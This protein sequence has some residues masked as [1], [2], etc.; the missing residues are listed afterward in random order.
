MCTIITW[1]ELSWQELSWQPLPCFLA[2][3][4]LGEWP[5]GSCTG[6]KWVHENRRLH[7][8]HVTPSATHHGN[9]NPTSCLLFDKKKRKQFI[10]F[11]LG[12]E[13]TPSPATTYSD[14][15]E[16]RISKHE[17]LTSRPPLR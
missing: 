14:T 12:I 10:D 16:K 6:G 15:K 7:R 3:S 2:M 13:Q 17:T 8:V 9:T 1:Q 4:E 11:Q 5:I